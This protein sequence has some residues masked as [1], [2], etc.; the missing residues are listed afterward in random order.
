MTI[1]GAVFF[2]SLIL[3]SCGGKDSKDDGA[4]VEDQAASPSEQDASTTQQD[5]STTGTEPSGTENEPSAETEEPESMDGVTDAANKTV[6]DAKKMQVRKPQKKFID[7]VILTVKQD[8]AYLHQKEGLPANFICHV[9]III[10]VQIIMY[11]RWVIM[12]EFMEEIK[13]INI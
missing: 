12:T 6:E 7:K 10:Q 3:S 13:N 11:M 2:A 8:M 9:G 1:I 5:A 4:K